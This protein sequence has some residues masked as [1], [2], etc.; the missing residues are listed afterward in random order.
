MFY[1]EL[2]I[3]QK[4]NIRS[5]FGFG[6]NKAE[7]EYILCGIYEVPRLCF[8]SPSKWWWKKL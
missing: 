1:Q 5:R 4:I 7:K 8:E 2:T 6:Y 3:N